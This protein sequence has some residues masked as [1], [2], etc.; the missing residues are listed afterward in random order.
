MRLTIHILNGEKTE[1]I[2]NIPAKKDEKGKMI[3]PA[4]KKTKRFT[5]NTLS[6]KNLKGRRDA[7]STLGRIR[8]LYQIAK[9][10]QGIKKGQEMVY[11][12][13]EK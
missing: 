1:K 7:E 6:F 11:F 2:V 9:W 12:S 5:Y 4:S 10:T 13:H 3:T 8:D